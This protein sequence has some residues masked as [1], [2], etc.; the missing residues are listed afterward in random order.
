LKTFIGGVAAVALLCANVTVAVAQDSPTAVT[1]PAAVTEAAPSV[2]GTMW[3]GTDSR[4]DFAQYTFLKG[5]QLRVR[6]PQ[7]T[8]GKLETT[9]TPGDTWSQSGT[10]IHFEINH[11]LTYEGTLDGDRMSGTVSNVEGEHWAWEVRRS[12]TIANSLPPPPKAGGQAEI[13]ELRRNGKDGYTWR[14][15]NWKFGEL[16]GEIYQE[17]HLHPIGEIH[18]LSPRGS[19][20]VANVIEITQIAQSV[21]A[22]PTFQDLEVQGLAPAAPGTAA[23]TDVTFDYA[24]QTLTLPLPP[25]NCLID[26]DSATG[27]ELYKLQEETNQ[28]QT[29]IG[30]LFADCAALADMEK[31]TDSRMPVFGMYMLMLNKG[32]QVLLP[33]GANTSAYV[34]NAL[35]GVDAATVERTADTA[36][37]AASDSAD[38]SKDAPPIP[39]TYD[40]NAIYLG[41]VWT[42]NDDKKKEKLCGVF[43]VTVINRVPVTLDTMGSYTGLESIHSLLAA[44]KLHVKALV[45]ANKQGQK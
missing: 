38:A 10:H 19:I 25:G 23:K 11:Y 12:S 42:A 4:G 28:G 9:E 37:A 30:A 31:N 14:D 40:E 1:A 41:A 27:Q 15:R 2:M 39:L 24:G 3:E 17:S 32:K 21:G 36:L 8:G 26:K 29:I 13:I 20:S 16:K 33:A 43:A 18:L 22:K 6:Q 5:G 45:D 7:L 44:Q 34:R 35:N